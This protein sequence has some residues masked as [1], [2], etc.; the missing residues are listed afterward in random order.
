MTA[1]GLPPELGAVQYCFG[2]DAS[3]ALAPTD[4]HIALQ[5]CQATQLHLEGTPQHCHQI[6]QS[7]NHSV[8]RFAHCAVILGY[9]CTDQYNLETVLHDLY[10]QPVHD[11]SLSR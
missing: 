8:L 2:S 1:P 3:H 6:T 10:S 11:Q 9:L 7:S 5:L 4:F